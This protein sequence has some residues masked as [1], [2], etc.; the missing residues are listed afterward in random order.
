MDENTGWIF[1]AVI[2]FLELLSTL[3]LQVTCDLNYNTIQYD[4]NL[5]FRQVVTFLLSISA[6][7]LYLLTAF[8]CNTSSSFK[9]EFQSF[10]SVHTR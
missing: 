4:T 6:M 7:S 9:P 5:E 10:I 3:S 8:N 2:G 1:G